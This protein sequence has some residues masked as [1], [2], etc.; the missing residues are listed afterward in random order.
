VIGYFEPDIDL[1]I[2]LIDRAL[3][4]NPSFALGWL[5]SGW[6]RLWAGQTDLG[7][8]HFQKF[9]RS[10]PLRQAPASM[11]IGVGHFL[12]HRHATIR[13]FEAGRRTPIPNNL[14]AIRRALEN[15]G[16]EF[17]PAR[18]GK[19]VGVRLRGDC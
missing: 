7:L 1:A 11:G 14:A 19:G 6:I 18:N 12:A 16:V 5:R 8:E 17:I 4:L 10:N 15:G 2:V 13:R 3:E 9:L